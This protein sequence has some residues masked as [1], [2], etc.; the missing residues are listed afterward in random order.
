MTET[1]HDTILSY[2]IDF[3]P[4]RYNQSILKKSKLTLDE[5]DRTMAKLNLENLFQNLF[6]KK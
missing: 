1:I 2:H 3:L 6:Y 4:E 5:N